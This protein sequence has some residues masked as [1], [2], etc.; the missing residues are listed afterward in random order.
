[1]L[2]GPMINITLAVL[3]G[4]FA[5]SLPQWAAQFSLIYWGVDAFTKLASSQTGIAINL[6]ALFA[7]GIALFLVGAWLF[8]RRMEL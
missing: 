8:K 5:F 3:G 4:A 7:Q 2:F 6:L 1:M